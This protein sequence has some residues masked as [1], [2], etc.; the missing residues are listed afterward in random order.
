MAIYLLAMFRDLSIKKLLFVKREKKNEPKRKEIEIICNINEWT[1][2]EIINNKRWPYCVFN[3]LPFFLSDVFRIH[4]FHTNFTTT[5][6]LIFWFTEM[7]IPTA[8]IGKHTLTL[9]YT[10]TPRQHTN[11]ENSFYRAPDQGVCHSTLPGMR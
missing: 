1:N 5:R 4:N 10:R 7:L 2:Q 8:N 3:M 11:T 9:I 6:P